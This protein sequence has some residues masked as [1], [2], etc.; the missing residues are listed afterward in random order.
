MTFRVSKESGVKINNCN[1][2][3]VDCMKSILVLLMPGLVSI[4]SAQVINSWTNATSGNWQDPK[5]SLGIRPGSSQTI[6]LTNQGWKAVAIG[7]NTTQNFPQSLNVSNV[8]LGGYTDSFNV[9][10]L[11]YAGYEVPLTAGSITVGSNSAMTIL[12]SAV[13]VTNTGNSRLEVGGT[14]NQGEFPAVNTSILSLGNIGPGIYNLTNGTLTVVTGY[15]GG[16]FT[17][18][19]N[20]YGG[21]NSVSTLRI[22][23]TIYG[24]G[25]AGEYDLYDG[26]LGGAVELHNGALMKQSGGTFVGSVWFDGTYELDGGLFTN[27]NLAIPTTDNGY[28][29]GYP[30]GRPSRGDVHLSG[31]WRHRDTD[32]GHF[33][34]FR[35][36]DRSRELTTL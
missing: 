34:Q 23:G 32:R 18:Q 28:T 3:T 25:G 5:W 35:A 27:A 30:A 4:A 6:M 14:V 8:F 19:L 13:N 31:R 11:N 9:L 17:G 7:A 22:M 24:Q 21:Y 2:K 1:M 20:Q 33:Y 12:A 36:I 16:A 10:L 26:A 15:V 29:M